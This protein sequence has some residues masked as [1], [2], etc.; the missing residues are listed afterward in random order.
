MFEGIEFLVAIATVASAAVS[1]FVN[2]IYLEYIRPAR[3]RRRARRDTLTKVGLPLLRAAK[4]ASSYTDLFLRERR[5]RWF[6]TDPDGMFRISLLYSLA[7]LFAWARRIEEEAF[8]DIAPPE[9]RAGAFHYAM[10]R[11]FKAMTSLS[12]FR[13]QSD[14]EREA[15][16]VA[17]VPR[18]ALQA[19][20]ELMIVRERAFAEDEPRI[21]SFHMFARRYET[22]EDFRRWM[23]KMGALF[24]RAERDGDAA[25]LT[26]VALLNTNLNTFAAFLERYLDVQS[27]RRERTKRV[28]ISHDRLL[29]ASVIDQLLRDHQRSDPPLRKRDERAISRRSRSSKS[30]DKSDKTT[31]GS[32]D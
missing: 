13:N 32:D 24:L 15:A 16:I 5:R 18:R 9:E 14:E 7:E 3:E 23:D 20:G 30:D 29:P 12:Y 27:T 8:I 4:S 11:V 21:L 26:R 17:A 6:E 31:N 1:L 19:V 28:Y 25:S 10:G 2:F 22:D